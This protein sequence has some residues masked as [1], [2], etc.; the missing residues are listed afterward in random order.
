MTVESKM[1]LFLSSR[2][3]TQFMVVE[4]VA[5][6]FDVLALVLEFDETFNEATTVVRVKFNVSL[7]AID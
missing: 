7:M 6:V 2:R 4:P 1:K 5:D 3:S